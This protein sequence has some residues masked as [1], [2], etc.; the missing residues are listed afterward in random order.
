MQA[1]WYPL[2][3]VGGST[4]SDMGCKHARLS[5]MLQLGHVKVGC[6]LNREQTWARN[7]TLETSTRKDSAQRRCRM[8][9][10][11]EEAVRDYWSY[12]GE[13]ADLDLM[14]FPDSG[15]FR[16]IAFITFAT[17]RCLASGAALLILPQAAR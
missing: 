8:C 10:V 14:R 3:S 1:T 12:C 15:R 4:C 7:A 5:P 6:C 13:I 16:G 11:Q 17:V 2:A 9:V